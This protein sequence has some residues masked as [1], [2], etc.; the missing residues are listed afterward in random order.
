M[1]TNDNYGIAATEVLAIIDYMELNEKKKISS[2]FMD[3]LK[4]KS[5]NSYKVEL[6]FSNPISDIKLSK[7]T[8]SLLAIMYRQF[9]CDEKEKREFNKILQENEEKFQNELKEKYNPND[10]FKNRSKTESTEK[11]TTNCV[12]M[13]EYK[14]SIL[15]KIINKIKQIF[16][17]H[18]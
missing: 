6:D 18:D 13:V 17:L 12:S 5:I 3:F 7:E 9:L 8:K 1:M 10:I 15:K 14:E 11:V 2:K 16:K 4:K